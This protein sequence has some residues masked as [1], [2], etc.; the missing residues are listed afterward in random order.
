MNFLT[1]RPQ[2]TPA[3]RGALLALGLSLAGVGCTSV[4][5]TARKPTDVE[6]RQH[7]IRVNENGELLDLNGKRVP[8]ESDYAE[9]NILA[10]LRAANLTSGRYHKGVLIFVHGGLNDYDDA[11]A[12]FAT[13]FAELEAAG[14]YPLFLIWPSGLTSTYL[15]HLFKIRQG[16]RGRNASGRLFT[17][18]TIPIVLVQDLATGLVRTPMTTLQTFGSD[19][20]TTVAPASRYG[21]PDAVEIYRKLRT[22]G[23]NVAIGY[24]Y[25]TP[26][27]MLLRSTSYF[28]TLPAKIATEGPIIDAL[29]RPAWD[30]MLRRTYMVFPGELAD[31]EEPR[32]P[33]AAPRSRRS[34]GESRL[35]RQDQTK[36]Q[37]FVNVARAARQAEVRASGFARVIDVL[38]EL[39]PRRRFAVTLVGHSMGTIVLNHLLQATTLR[40]DKIIYL[41]AAC[42]IRDYAD[43]VLPYLTQHTRAISYNLSLHPMAED[44]ELQKA[45]LDLPPRGSLLVWIDNFLSNP[46]YEQERTFGRW[47]NLF[48]PSPTGNSA[49][50]DILL[51]RRVAGRVHFRAFGVGD[52]DA[53]RGRN[54]QWAGDDDY[55]PEKPAPETPTRHGGMSEIRFWDDAVLTGAAPRGEKPV[56][57]LPAK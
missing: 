36:T 54:F 17:A 57:R 20:Q 2:R 47:T 24:D 48:L 55:R 4:P 52:G 22:H 15:E 12:H 5:T 16:R 35:A 32:D 43:A 45:F 42:S 53:P 44:G 14:Y 27:A 6:A 40:A 21:E 34:P 9:T 30:N 8:K 51:H 29:G 38:E 31:H 7:V 18:A 3:L 10:P 28:L 13:R 41:A 33:D 37:G 23:D 11:F 19:L 56:E 1:K 26:G 46:T 25:K 49:I 50:E 39:Q